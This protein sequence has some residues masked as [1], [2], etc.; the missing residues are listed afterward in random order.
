[1]YIKPLLK[2]NMVKKFAHAPTNGTI[3]IKKAKRKY[4]S[5]M[6]IF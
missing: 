1:M 2:M 6:S 5:K 3:Q 4:K